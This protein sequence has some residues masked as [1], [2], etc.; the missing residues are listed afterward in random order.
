MKRVASLCA[1]IASLLFGTSEAVAQAR[2]QGWSVLTGRTI[3]LNDTAL[4]FQAGWPGIS[5]TLLHGMTPK[6]DLGGIFNFN[7]G[8]EGDVNC[9]VRPGIKFQGLLR[10]NLFDSNKFN[11]GINFA[12][13]PLFYFFPRRTTVAGIA[14]P[15][16]LEFGIPATPA[17]NIGL[18]FEMPMFVVFESNAL[19]GQLVLPVLFGGGIEYFLDRSLALTFNMRMGP[20]IFTADGFT[21]FDFQALMGLAVKL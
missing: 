4:H 8:F 18:A 5:A 17:L 21:D 3:G 7:Y 2:G 16:G 12:P 9:C 14:I 11:V 13:G 6:L 10:A 1:L 19:S 15:F 20:M